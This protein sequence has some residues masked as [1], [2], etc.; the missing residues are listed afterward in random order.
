MTKLWKEIDQ[1]SIDNMIDGMHMRLIKL[2]ETD[3]KGPTIKCY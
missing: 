3:G 1:C 2:I